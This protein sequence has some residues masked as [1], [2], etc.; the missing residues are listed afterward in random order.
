MRTDAQSRVLAALQSG[1]G[2]QAYLIAGPSDAPLGETLEA[3]ARLLLCE[4]EPSRRPCGA[5]EACRL[6]EAGSHPDLLRLE[7]EAGKKQIGV[8]PVRRL[9]GALA[10]ASA[11]RGKRVVLAA[12]AH[13][14]TPAA[15]NALLKTLEEPPEGVHFLLS[16]TESGL[17][18]TIRSRCMIVR[19]PG[20]IAAETQEERET[21]RAAEAV[22]CALCQKKP[23]DRAVYG[24][25]RTDMD[26]VME[27]QAD[28]CRDALAHCVGA[29]TLKSHD[30]LEKLAA[31][32][33]KK[34]LQAI[35]V[36]TAGR[37]RLLQ[38]AG[39]A[40]T[41]DWLTVELARVFR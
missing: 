17:L 35:S 13:R 9:E 4:A 20:E 2:A 12:D 34:L 24:E 30:E 37:K 7:P 19:L 1:R 39:T 40:V 18:A 29:R 10:S 21:R 15:Q 8:D 23:A 38:N 25:N 32:G 16:G 28:F 31:C 5:C 11:R 6:L 26:R 33:E 3:G 14:M 41:V 22:L 27:L 36:L